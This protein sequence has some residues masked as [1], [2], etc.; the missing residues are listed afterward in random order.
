MRT[1]CG[2]WKRLRACVADE[3]R[4]R[5]LGEELESVVQMHM[6]EYLLAGMTREEARRRALIEVGGVEQVRQ[7]VRNRR[8]WSSLEGL[9]RDTKC[10]VRACARTRGSGSWS[11]RK[12]C[13]RR[14][15]GNSRCFLL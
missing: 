12:W 1:L 9:A 6:D 2:W 5:D 8:G 14:S 11:G 4:D 7:A 3:N 13:C 10:A 15:P